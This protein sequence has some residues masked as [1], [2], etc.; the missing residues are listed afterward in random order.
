MH[1]II[2]DLPIKIKAS[3]SREHASSSNMWFSAFTC[4][5]ALIMAPGIFATSNIL[6]STL[7][8]RFQ[9]PVFPPTDNA[10]AF[11][12]KL[13]CPVFTVVNKTEDYEERQYVASNWVTTN[14]QGVDYATASRVMFKKLYDYIDGTNVKHMKIKMTNPVLVQ[15]EAG[16]GPACKS[17][18]TQSFFVSTSM[19]DPPQPSD[20]TV[21]FSS[22]P[23]QKVF[24]RTF[25]GFATEPDWVKNAEALGKALGRDS[26]SFV[27]SSFFT[28][29]YDSPFKVLNRHNEVWYIAM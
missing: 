2:E 13:D 11:C 17:N 15:V 19:K 27:Q 18:F 29:E 24:V 3:A 12:N 21:F 28:A 25:D 7:V 5:S 8:R 1:L 14:E 26:R 16:P 6:H 10:P 22:F 23:S 4:L 9:H 20:K